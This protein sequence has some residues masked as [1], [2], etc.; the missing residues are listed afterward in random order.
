M[1]SPKT[2]NAPTRTSTMDTVPDDARTDAAW[3]TTATCSSSHT[4]SIHDQ[5]VNNKQSTS[6]STMQVSYALQRWLDQKPEEEH[7]K[8]FIDTSCRA[9]RADEYE[10]G[11]IEAM[12]LE[13]LGSAGLILT[14]I[15]R[16]GVGRR[17]QNPCLIDGG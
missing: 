7:W 12:V 6:S 13:E 8:L 1:S 10:E 17:C 2:S 11:V 5:V 3:S 9:R 14:K 16:E 15:K 4:Q